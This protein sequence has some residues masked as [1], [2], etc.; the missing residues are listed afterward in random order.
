[1]TRK[2]EQEK[3]DDKKMERFKKEGRRDGKIRTVS[4]VFLR[5]PQAMVFTLQLR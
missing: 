5:R 4:F 1:M 3:E 2:R